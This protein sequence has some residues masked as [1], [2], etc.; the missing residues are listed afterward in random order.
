LH[1]GKLRGDL[2][3]GYNVKIQKVE[4]PTNTS[5]YVNFPAAIAEATG[6]QKGETMEWLVEDRNTFI[7]KRVRSRRSFLKKQ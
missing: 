6:V 7:L 5:F 3:L 2:R 4:R 1:L